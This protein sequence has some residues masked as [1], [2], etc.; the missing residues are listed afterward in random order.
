MTHRIA[1][2]N[3]TICSFNSC[4]A[5]CLEEIHLQTRKS[6]LIG[7]I[8]FID[9]GTFDSFQLAYKSVAA[10]M[11]EKGLQMPFNVL[12]QADCSPVSIEMWL[13]N[14]AQTIDYL[15][16]RGMRYTRIQ[17]ETGLS[18]CGTGLCHLDREASLQEQL[19][20]TFRLLVD[21]L[22]QEGLSLSDVVR[23]WNYVPGI[24]DV[25]QS[26][27]KTV[28]HYQVFNE[29]RKDW[30]SK[31]LFVDGYPAATGIGV[32]TGPFSID[33]IAKPSTPSLRKSG[34]YNP[35]QLNA[36]HYA[37][38]HLVG[39]ALRGK[40]KNPPLFERAKLLDSNN[41]SQ[42]FVSGTA[43]ILGQETVGVGDVQKQ[44]EVAINN[45]LELTSPHVTQHDKTFEFN[46]IR[47]YIKDVAHRDAI[48]TICENHFPHIPKTYVLA[49]VCRDNLL[50]EIEGEALNL[51]N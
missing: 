49:D 35:K 34:L 24:L 47:V 30:Y 50:M 25:V 23:Q 15:S 12:A 33:F 9:A 42:V 31:T 16:Y 41:E 11:N 39:D 32:K 36:Y 20:E 48:M 29:V 5:D 13:D 46:Y 28:Q 19:E 26:H 51:K 10:A 43:A 2:C 37:Q 7:V 6:T 1:Y 21:I 27:G 3:P 45:M 18:I 17:S 44:T 38:Q 14:T 22:Q 4:L 8:F 40:Q